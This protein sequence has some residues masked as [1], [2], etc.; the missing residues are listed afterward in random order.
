M[1]AE[2]LR[3]VPVGVRVT[4]RRRLPDGT[5][6]DVVGVV[7]AHDEQGVTL[8]TQRH[9]TVR[10][11]Y[12]DVTVHRVI[13]PVPW[14]VGAFLGRAQVAVLDLGAVLRTLE[15]GGEL[16][17]PATVALVDSLLSAGTPVLVLDDGSERRPE[18]LG[19]LDLAPLVPLLLTTPGPGRARPS[20]EAFEAVHAAIEDRMGR[21]VPRAGVHFT[22]DRPA[23]V[24]AARA[25]G[26]QGRVFTPPAPGQ[27]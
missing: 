27:R 2:P 12:A 22:H 19:R 18:E 3:Q 4:V 21:L 11:A 25:F 1:A 9:G 16:T 14:R 8:Q 10:V 15:A 5:V 26:W 20:V 17:G 23:D 6:G 24:E 7:S 13:R